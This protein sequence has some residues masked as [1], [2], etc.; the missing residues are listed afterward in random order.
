M[1]CGSVHRY[2]RE[3]I[4]IKTNIE[5]CIVSVPWG[6]SNIYIWQLQTSWHRLLS[7]RSFH[8]KLTTEPVEFVLLYE[9]SQR[10]TK[11]FPTS[12]LLVVLLNLLQMRHIFNRT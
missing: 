2:V 5:K 3:H 8:V 1:W 9:V 7:R 11:Q 12:K 6:L 4:L 10:A